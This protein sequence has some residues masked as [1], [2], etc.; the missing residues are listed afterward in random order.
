MS[1][2][3]NSALTCGHASALQRS[4]SIARRTRLMRSQGCQRRVS[5]LSLPFRRVARSHS[6]RVG[7]VRLVDP[8]VGQTVPIGER[9]RC[10]RLILLTADRRHPDCVADE[11]SLL[12]CDVGIVDGPVALTA[13]GAPGTLFSNVFRGETH[14]AQCKSEFPQQRKVGETGL[15]DLPRACRAKDGR[16]LRRLRSGQSADPLAYH[17]AAGRRRFQQTSAAV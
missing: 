13:V 6:E 8:L 10:N 5:C 14:R 2:F 12:P 1:A 7:A 3:L 4:C 16:P 9:S 11:G 15:Q 17:S